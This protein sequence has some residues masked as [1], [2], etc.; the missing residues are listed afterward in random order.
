[1]KKMHILGIGVLCLLLLAAP[2]MACT[3]TIKKDTDPDSIVNFKFAKGTTTFALDDDGYSG[4]TNCLVNAADSINCYRSKAF[5]VSSGTTSTFRETSANSGNYK[6]AGITCTATKGNDCDVDSRFY[7]SSTGSSW[8]SSFLT[9]DS[10]VQVVLKDNENVECT[11]RNKPACVP[12][13]EVCDG[14]DNDCDL[15][16]DED[17]DADRDRYTVCEGDCNDTD[18]TINPGSS[19]I[20]SQF[21][22]SQKIAVNVLGK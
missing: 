8:H 3:I 1:M 18:S 20:C 21:Y 4:G 13:I 22:N 12:C 15:L 9:G 11:F 2:A 5:S 17:F 19:E 14:K 10:W 16:V 6:L 7:F